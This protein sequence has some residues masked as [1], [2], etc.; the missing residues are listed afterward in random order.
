MHRDSQEGLT[1]RFNFEKN[2]PN[3]I[4]FSVSLYNYYYSVENEPLSRLSQALRWLKIYISFLVGPATY[5]QTDL[6]LI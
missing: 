3:P 2:G 6:L 1:L 4:F 5:S